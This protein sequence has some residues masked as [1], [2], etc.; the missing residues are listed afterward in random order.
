MAASST[1]G[2]ASCD[3][4]PGDL[5]SHMFEAL[6]LTSLGRALCVS[7][8]WREASSSEPLWHRQA[9]RL[10]YLWGW[11]ERDT[12]ERAAKYGSWE[13]YVRRERQLERR[14]CQAGGRALKARVLTDRMPLLSL[15]QADPLQMQS[16][17]LSFQVAIPYR[18]PNPT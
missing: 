18:N 17:H 14:W 12:H 1:A 15:L 3:K 7:R 10:G 8:R 5:V 2:E 9:E 13:A 4:L 16:S 11:S 6:P